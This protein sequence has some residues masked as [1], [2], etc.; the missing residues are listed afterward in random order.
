MHVHRE[1]GMT[2]SDHTATGRVKCCMED[3]HD[4]TREP[5]AGE[6]HRLL[7]PALTMRAHVRH[8]AM[9]RLQITAL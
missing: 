4:C 3:L 6:T 9:P 8:T 7:R 2:R 1:G 5:S